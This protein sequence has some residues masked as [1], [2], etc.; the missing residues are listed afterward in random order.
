M[1]ISDWSSDVCSSDLPR[2]SHTGR[3]ASVAFHNYQQFLADGHVRLVGPHDGY[4]P[5]EQSRDFVHVD[6][7]V[8]VNLHCLDNPGMRG[9]FNCGTGRA[10]PFNDIARTVVATLREL[11]DEAPLDLAGMV[12]AGLLE[13]LQLPEIGRTAR[14]ER[15]WYF[16]E[17]TVGRVAIQKKHTP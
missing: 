15:W 1:R 4:G 14:R 8:A 10:Q 7:V 3:M 17:I 9:V 2:E 13:Y 16:G 5:G 11:R 12:S 6:D